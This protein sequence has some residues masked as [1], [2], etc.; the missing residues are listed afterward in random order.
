M[1]ETR[2]GADRTADLLLE[3]TLASVDRAEQVVIETARRAGFDEDD[4]YRIG[5][6]VRETMVN[7]VAH[8][9]RYNAKK[10]VRLVVDRYADRLEIEIA[11]EGQGF[12]ASEAPDPLSEENL[13]GQSGR[14]LLM[15]R[16]FMDDLEMRRREPQGTIVKLIK[17]RP[18]VSR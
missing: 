4:Q 3:S 17:R 15:V 2:D 6:A 16:A 13:L 18:S 8:G 7:A 5:I 9:N 14:G 10:K 11:D 12:T 1:P